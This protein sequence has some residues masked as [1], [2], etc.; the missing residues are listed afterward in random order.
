MTEAGSPW[1]FVAPVAGLLALLW[2]QPARGGVA[3]GGD[4]GPAPSEEPRVAWISRLPG[5]LRAAALLGLAW[6]AAAPMRRVPIPAPPGEGVALMV[7][8]DVSASMAEPGRGG[9]RKLDVAVGELARFLAA[10]DGDAVGLVTFAGDALVRVPPSTD[11]TGI[12]EALRSR[13]PAGLGDGTAV[14]TALGLAANQLRGFD[15]RSL[16]IVLVS[17]GLSNAG[18]LDP[19]TAARAASGVGIRVYVME[20]RSEPGQLAHL[21]PVA[22]AGGGRHFEISDGVGV[23]EAYRAID[24]LEPGRLPGTPT[25]AQVPLAPWLLW[26]IAGCLLGERVVR[27]SPW[28][29]LP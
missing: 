1:L 3:I 29:V 20:I 9:R 11:R 5:V 27:A 6:L 12:E 18:A 28:G 23:T 26:W 25:P 7:A 2:F 17:D 22:A 21:A 8:L 4:G 24:A 14:G 10:R 16:A 19:V 15:A 13:G